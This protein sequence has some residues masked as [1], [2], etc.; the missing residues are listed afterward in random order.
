MAFSSEE[1]STPPSGI[2]P[3]AAYEPGTGP[4]PPYQ[5][6]PRSPPRSNPRPAPPQSPTSAVSW[7]S[8]PQF[9]S[10][11]SHPPSIYVDAPCTVDQQPRRDTDGAPIS[12]EEWCKLSFLSLRPSACSALL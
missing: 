8:E 1:V 11:E 9:S 12:A 5:P 10:W 2:E 4:A 7:Q 6:T 3:A